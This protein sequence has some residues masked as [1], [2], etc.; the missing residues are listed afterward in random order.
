MAI[1]ESPQT[2]LI[3]RKD[4]QAQTGL[5]RSTLYKLVSSGDFPAPV[6]ITTKAVAWTRSDVDSWIAGR[7]AASKAA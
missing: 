3:R 7:I 6:R 4:V 2:S 1:T 5:A